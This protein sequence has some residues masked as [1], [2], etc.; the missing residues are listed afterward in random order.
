[1]VYV[2]ISAGSTT[3]ERFIRRES[4]TP[5]SYIIVIFLNVF[6]RTASHCRVSVLVIDGEFMNDSS[7]EHYFFI[8]VFK[9]RN[10]HTVNGFDISFV[11]CCFLFILIRISLSVL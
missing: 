7:V 11:L 1:M 8:I 2:G 3:L 6:S 4:V 10:K 5:F 9:L